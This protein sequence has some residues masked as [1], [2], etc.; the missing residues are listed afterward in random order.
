MACL[1]L[2]PR[3]TFTAKLSYKSAGLVGNNIEA[4]CQYVELATIRENDR[5]V[6]TVFETK[7][8]Y[9]AIFK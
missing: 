9:A 3:S 7:I 2:T 4:L 1:E 5:K 6:D 8:I